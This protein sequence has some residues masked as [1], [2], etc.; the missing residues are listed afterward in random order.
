MNLVARA[1]DNIIGHSITASP[2]RPKW[3][4]T[5]KMNALAW[6]GKGDMRFVEVP[7]PL[8]TDPRD[9]IVKVTACTICGSDCHLYSGN[10][11]DMKPGDI[12][13]HEGMGIV[14]EKGSEVKTLE[15]GMRVVMSFDI[16][17]GECTH[18]KRG[19]FSCCDTSN[20]S[21]LMATMYGHRTSAMFGYSHLTG[22][23]PGSQAEWV[24]VPYA[25]VNCLPIPDDVPD[26]KALYLSDIIPT[27]YHGTE[28][29][30]VGP[31]KTVAVWGLGPVGQLICRWSQIRGAKQVIGI[32]CVPERLDLA[33]R[34][35]G[36]DLINFKT[37][38][39]IERMKQLCPGGPDCGIE[40]AGFE[41]A[42]SLTHKAERAV[43][44]ETDTSDIINEMIY[45]V[46]KAGT[47]TLIGVYAGYTNHFN[48]GAF[49]EKG[50]HMN[51]G[52]APV[53]HY[54]KD[55]L[56]RVR[57]GEFDPTFVI[58]HRLNLSDGPEAYKKFYNKEGGWLKTFIRPTSDRPTSM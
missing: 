10:M 43:G 21:N 15:V 42:K 39:V 4:E 53:Q 45:T 19:E 46:R 52:Q 16:A 13:G 41:Y 31:G 34:V 28:L 57:S 24:R 37:E 33:K 6:Y 55:L 36:I 20:D 7:R 56:Q 51:G 1:A 54:W 40:A 25:D 47:I 29:A 8:L 32:D 14:V 58:S 26:E 12:L 35:M 5:K 50:M 2:C 44:L 3:D 17:C 22:G 18:C 9:V 11:P 38:N 30:G 49:M 27:S 23:V 48:I